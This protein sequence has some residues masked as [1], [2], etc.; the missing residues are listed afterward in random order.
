MKQTMQHLLFTSLILLFS[1]SANPEAMSA[2][3]PAYACEPTAED[4]MGPLYVQGAPERNQ[5]GTGY[6]LMGRV[7]SAADCTPIAG[8]MIEIWMAG[9]HGH[10]GDDWRATLFS[11][12]NGSY[13]L[14]SHVPPN[15]GTGRAHIHVKVSSDGYKTLITQHYPAK[16][17]GEA[18]FDL[19]LV[20]AR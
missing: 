8:A 4:E 19:T 13:Y 18:M 6:L 2:E 16:N 12:G 10:Y 9:P 3:M 1:L 14:Q 5:I 17:A 15:Y 7:K 11:D 20:P